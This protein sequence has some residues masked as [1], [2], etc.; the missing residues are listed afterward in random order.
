M[1]DAGAHNIAQDEATCVVFGMLKEA[2]RRGAVD[3]VVPLDQIARAMT[4]AVQPDGV[5]SWVIILHY[6]RNRRWC[7]TV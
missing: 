5:R 1:K 3:E 7:S 6:H 4:V 2:I